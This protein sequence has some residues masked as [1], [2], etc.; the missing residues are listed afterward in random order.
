MLHKLCPRNRLLAINVPGNRSLNINP[1]TKKVSTWNPGI[2]KAPV[3]RI[4]S[5][6]VECAAF[7]AEWHGAPGRKPTVGRPQRSK[8]GINMVLRDPPL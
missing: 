6:A 7:S 8:R 3:C 1:L 5:L 2:L 4:Y